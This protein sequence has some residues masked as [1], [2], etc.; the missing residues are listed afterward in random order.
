MTVTI[1]CERCDSLFGAPSYSDAP[2]LCPDCRFRDA[3]SVR[4]WH[5]DR[6]DL[7]A[8][9]D[10]LRAARDH[11]MAERDAL[12]AALQPFAR[13]ADVLDFYVPEACPEDVTFPFDNI[14]LS[15]DGPPRVTLQVADY[16]RARTALAGGQP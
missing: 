15:E 2:N 1:P 12:R 3:L 10:D 16:E 14:R 11:Y 7:Q 8:E 6:D 4:P 5:P 13:V 9:V